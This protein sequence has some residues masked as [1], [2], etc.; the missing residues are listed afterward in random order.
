MVGT[1]W[2]EL[3]FDFIFAAFTDLCGDVRINHHGFAQRDKL[4]PAG[5]KRFGDVAAGVEVAYAD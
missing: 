4:R 1:R 2:V 3:R 5:V